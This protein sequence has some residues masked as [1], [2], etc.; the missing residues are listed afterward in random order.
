MSDRYPFEFKQKAVEL[1]TIERKSILGFNQSL[2]H[3]V[4]F[5][6]LTVN[7]TFHRRS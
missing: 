3:L 7:R 2:Q 5:K 1:V 4:R 6:F